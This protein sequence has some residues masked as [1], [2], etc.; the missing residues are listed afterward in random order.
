MLDQLDQALRGEGWRPASEAD[1][2]PIVTY[3][4]I[5]TGHK[6]TED[7]SFPEYELLLYWK[8]EDDFTE[9]N[10]ALWNACNDAI[11][12]VRQA[13]GNDDIEVEIMT[14]DG[15]ASLTFIDLRDRR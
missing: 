2:S 14:D 1:L 5:A 9:R 12:F 4:I 6:S 8:F 15:R 10:T 7:G 13:A 3:D 11:P